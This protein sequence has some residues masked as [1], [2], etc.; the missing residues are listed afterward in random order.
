MLKILLLISMMIPVISCARTPDVVRIN[1]QK[2][3]QFS[4]TTTLTLTKRDPSDPAGFKADLESALVAVG[5]NLKSDLVAQDVAWKDTK[6]NDKF[7]GEDQFNHE[8]NFKEKVRIGKSR[9]FNS[10]YLG[11]LTYG[12]IAQSLQ[13]ISAS[14]T[15]I[16]LQSGAIAVTVT[17]PNTYGPSNEQFAA[18]IAEELAKAVDAKTGVRVV[19]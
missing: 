8:Q 5:F 19:P 14:I 6:K 13:V 18:R 7:E 9:E 12:Y 3:S 17:A 15:I 4:K 16:D 1:V 2:S 11:T 10:Q